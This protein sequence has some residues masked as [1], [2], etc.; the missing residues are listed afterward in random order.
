[1]I[2]YLLTISLFSLPPSLL[3]VSSIMTALRPALEAA[4]SVTR[5]TPSPSSGSGHSSAHS[6]PSAPP[7]APASPALGS[8][9]LVLGAMG[10]LAV[11]DRAEVMEVVAR[12]EQLMQASL[13]PS[14]AQ[15]DEERSP[16][17]GQDQPPDCWHPPP[18]PLEPSS[19][20][21]RPYDGGPEGSQ[22]RL[23]P[24]SRPENLCKINSR[25]F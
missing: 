15:S 8:V 16:A 5:D 19:L 22:T 20:T 24:S 14:P 25:H 2:N 13:P 3:A 12:L 4:V 23:L 1:M 17:G 18:S 21:P 11:A 6:S 7:P 10:R 9:D